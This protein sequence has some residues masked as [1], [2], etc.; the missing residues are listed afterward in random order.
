LENI[1]PLLKANPAYKL[2]VT[3]HSLG[4]ALAGLVSFFLACDLEIEMFASPRF[5]DSNHLEAVQVLEKEK[6]LR[7]C[8]IVN[9]NDLVAVVPT[10]YYYHGG[11]QVRLNENNSY[12]AEIT[13]PKINDTMFN[14]WRWTWS[15]SLFTNID[16]SFDYKM[17]SYSERV[18]QSK[19]Y[20]ENENLNQLYQITDLTG[21]G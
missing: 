9:I 12:P 4:G 6:R 7:S 16:L 15:N 14:R 18:E 19:T 3:G 21:F 10:K 5:G 13:F 8:R 11:F 17:S 2:Y 20:L 1:K